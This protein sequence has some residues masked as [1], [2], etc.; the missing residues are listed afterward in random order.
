MLAQAAD[1][2]VRA[3]WHFGVGVVLC[4]MELVPE[5][6]SLLPAPAELSLAFPQ[7]PGAVTNVSQGLQVC[8]AQAS[9]LQHLFSEKCMAAIKILQAAQDTPAF[10]WSDADKQVVHTALQPPGE[11]ESENCAGG[12]F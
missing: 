9:H 2:L 1:E 4:Q 10:V 7:A 5:R 8:V 12:G 3:R 11:R 6:D